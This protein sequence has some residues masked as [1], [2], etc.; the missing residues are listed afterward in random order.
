[1]TAP[2]QTLTSDPLGSMGRRE[3]YMYMYSMMP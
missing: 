1:M 3:E 2:C